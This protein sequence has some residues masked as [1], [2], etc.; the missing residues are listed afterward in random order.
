MNE[1]DNKIMQGRRAFMQGASLLLTGTAAFSLTPNFAWA[2]SD[3]KLEGLAQACYAMYPHQHVPRNFYK[4]C[5]QGLLDKAKGDKALSDLLDEGL[6]V[7]DAV[8]SMPFRELSES[9]QALALQRVTTHPF[10]QTVRGHTVVGLYNI[11]GIWDYFGYQGPSF[12]KGG[13]IRRG[14][15]DIFWLKDV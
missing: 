1:E 8:Y 7:L 13:Y 2:A 11:P 12:P 15:N 5:A 10:F 14:L 4:A 3:E 6:A 9:D